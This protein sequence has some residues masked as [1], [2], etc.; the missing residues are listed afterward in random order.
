[1]SDCSQR[2]QAAP[3]VVLIFAAASA[4]IGYW[5]GR[6][7]AIRQAGMLLAAA[8]GSA[9]QAGES[10]AAQTR[11]L[12]AAMNASAHPFCSDSELAYFRHLLYQSTYLKEA[13]RVRNGAI[14]CS[15]MVGGA[16]LTRLPARPGVQGPDGVKLYWDIVAFRLGEEPIVTVQ[17]G[18]SYVVADF[19]V[20]AEGIPDYV[21]IETHPY[22]A[23]ERKGGQG[24]IGSMS[25]GVS[26]SDGT[27]VATKCSK[28]YPACTTASIALRD[29][30]R[31]ER[32]LWLA[33]T[34]L[35]T[36][37][38]AV[39]SLLWIVIYRRSCSMEQQFRRAISKGEIVLVY[40]PIVDVV[41][42]RIVGA[43][44]LARWNGEDGF[45]VSPEVF[46]RVAEERR[47]MSELT[48]Y[49]V[50]RALDDFAP[51]VRRYP[52]L[53]LSV[54]VA[55]SDLPDPGFQPMLTAAVQ[56]TGVSRQNLVLEVTET[57]DARCDETIQAISHL[58]QA[59]HPIHIDDF[60]TG[61]SSLS[62]L[63]DLAVDA[64]KIDRSFTRC[65]GT[66][67]VNVG[68]LPQVLAMAEALNLQVIVEGIET[69]DQAAYFLNSRI[70]ILAQGWLFGR[71]API[72]EFVRLIAAKEGGLVRE[73]VFE[74]ETE[75]ALP[76]AAS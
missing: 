67:S 65:I 45:P 76:S 38:G 16:A 50:N 48:R 44:A 10:Y 17:S 68:I 33:I 13:G 51:I 7:L 60:G 19:R 69:P 61:Y 58:R 71:P 28:L 39:L 37:S 20:R 26:M 35:S 1:V 15:A 55:A 14:A 74:K 34:A 70:R 3:L 30:L 29:A 46:V 49:V 64:I 53:R 8:A 21:H 5:L 24:E 62:Y 32:S 9:E 54:N 18:D 12:L 11:R 63:N 6:E 41:T 59:G 42:A 57:C 31:V 75:L 22:K 4:L 56:R 66:D 72:Y 23:G 73:H 2:L 43:E 40:Q 27:L 52:H 47:F 36:L 25:E